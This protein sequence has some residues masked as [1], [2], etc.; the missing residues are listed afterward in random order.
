MPR[1]YPLLQAEREVLRELPHLLH[2]PLHLSDQILKLRL[3]IVLHA[4]R[5][6][7]RTSQ[8]HPHRLRPLQP[9]TLQEPQL[10]NQRPLHAR[11]QQDRVPIRQ[12]LEIRKPEA[13]E[14]E[15]RRPELVAGAGGEEAGVLVDDAAEAVVGHLEVVGEEGED[16]D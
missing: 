16:G 10:R 9:Q 8:H 4:E 6:Q 7:R 3:E 13:A 5:E 11:H 1:L 2:L 14:V 15:Q 12:R